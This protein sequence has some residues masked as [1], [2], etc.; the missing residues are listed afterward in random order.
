MSRPQSSIWAFPKAPKQAHLDS[1][2]PKIAHKFGRIK[3][4]L[5]E[6]ENKSCS[7]IWVDNKSV[8]EPHPKTPKSPFKPQK[9][10]T[11]QKFVQNCNSK[12]KR[13]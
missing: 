5:K 6:E 8:F 13:A 4:E 1:K 12:L 3:S 10:K 9:A 2:K 7:F 11:T